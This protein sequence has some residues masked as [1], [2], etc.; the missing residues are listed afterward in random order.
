M[1]TAFLVVE[2]SEG[3]WPSQRLRWQ[4]WNQPWTDP[5]RRRTVFEWLAA[6]WRFKWVA[7]MTGQSS[8]ASTPP[9]ISKVHILPWVW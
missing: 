7:N 2:A 5:Q 8:D 9:T 4:D 6:R 1:M 3:F